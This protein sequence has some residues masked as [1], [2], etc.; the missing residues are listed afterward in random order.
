MLC[1]YAMVKPVVG[2]WPDTR[3][4]V[5]IPSGAFLELV[6]GESVG[7]CNATW[8]GRAVMVF[9]EDVIWIRNSLLIIPNLQV[10]AWG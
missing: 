3:V 7:I 9:R 2:F 10:R 8:N 6:R 4:V 1:L 5:T